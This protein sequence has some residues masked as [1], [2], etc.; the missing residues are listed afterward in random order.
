[1]KKIARQRPPRHILIP[2]TNILWHEKKDVCVHPDFDSFWGEYGSKYEIELAIPS[3]VLGELMYQ[4]TSSALTT[5]ERI[6]SQFSNL[7]SYSKN[8]YTHKITDRQ[9]R[10]DIKAK[11][12]AWMSSSSAI[13][14][15]TPVATIDWSSLINNAIWRIPPFTEDNNK[16]IEKGF[17]D[18]LILETVCFIVDFREGT[19]IVFITDDKLLLTAAKTRLKHKVHLYDT[20]D[21]FSS[22]LRLLDEELTN[23]FVQDLQ[24]RAREKFHGKNNSGL[25]YR[26]KLVTKIREQF[27][28]EF[29][30]PAYIRSLGQALAIRPQSTNEAWE[31]YSSEGIW[32]K[33]PRFVSLENENIFTWD[34]RITFVQLFRVGEI[35]PGGL[36]GNMVPQWEEKLRKL[37]FQVIWKAHVGRDARFLKMEVV[38]INLADKTFEPATAD[39]IRLYQI[40][41]V[42]DDE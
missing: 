27:G 36:L 35:G 42:K 10:N 18:A 17:R 28:A 29:R 34:S 16:E 7:S 40:E 32:I 37:N 13:L 5:L 26:E 24:K 19:D 33:A 8:N 6:N 1:M 11:F 38:E 31:R 22:Y 9:V 14:V 23:K 20:L 41:R 39:E 15:E 2:D 30:P 4:H 12:D 3:V 25:L 21:E